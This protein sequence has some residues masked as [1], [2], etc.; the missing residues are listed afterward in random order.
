MRI[1]LLSAT[2]P[3]PPTQGGTQVRTFNL[4]R[5][6][7]QHHEV[8]LATLRTP[9]VQD[10]EITALREFVTDLILFDRPA[11]PAVNPVT[12]LLRL[13]QFIATGQ[14]S[15]VRSSYSPEL[16]AWVD[17]AVADGKFDVIT[18]EHSV[19][20]AYIRPQFQRTV[21]TVVNVHSSVY[22]S[23]RNQ[24]Q[25]GTTENPLRDRIYL[26][27]LKRYEQQFSQK[28]SHIVVTTIDDRREFQTFAPQTP[29]SV[30]PNGVDFAAFPLRAQD[31]GG[32]RLI[33]IGAMDNL[34]NI[35]AARY[36]AREIFPQ[37][38]QRYPEATLALVG[39]RPVPEVQE[40]AQ[41]PGVTVTGQVPSMADFLHR[42]TVCVIPMR[43]GYGIKNKTLEAMAAGIPV[44][45]SDRGLEGLQV[46][47]LSYGENSAAI[48]PLRALRANDVTEYVESIAQLLDNISLRQS[49]SQSARAYIEAE[50]TWEGAGQR[51][52][53]VL[54]GL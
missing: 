4:L 36:L 46:D 20:E 43:T 53:Q 48:G 5:Y 1:L 10:S 40:L 2:F 49:L 3:Y 26:Q 17:R 14:P 30:I 25:T 12:K 16:Q 21:R 33:F 6:L 44:V 54:T 34:A 8:T 24:L 19:N 28:F 42:A 32:Q 29:V 45:A 27:L 18:C 7:Q 37:V 52:E 22:A 9:E 35:D 41:I 39:S 50:F 51:Y 47:R 38:R 23:C 13:G 31:P 11:N 15:G